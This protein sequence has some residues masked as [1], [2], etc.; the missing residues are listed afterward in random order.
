MTLLRV[1]IAD[2]EPLSRDCVRLALASHADVEVVGEC[3]DG[4]EAAE[5]IPRL[6]PDLVFLDVRMPGLDGFGVIEKVGAARMPPVVF[7]TA[8]D[9]HAIRA[10]SAHALDYVLKPFDDARFAESL[11]R[12]RAQ[13]ALRRDSELGRRLAAL[14]QASGS[15]PV[16]RL[17]V[18]RGEASCFVALDD[19]ECLAAERNYVR[20]HHRGGADIVRRTLDHLLSE[21]AG[22]RLVRVHRS[23]AVNVAHVREIRPW[24]SGDCIAVLESGREV[25][26]SRTYRS[27]LLKPFA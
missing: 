22:A 24:F 11:G 1:V 2:D 18:S 16:T 10:F 20:I 4:L 15:R 12:A 6:A 26:V 17:L 21:L 25:R 8:F 7:L 9:E 3:T 27:T 13:I 19:I 5:E 14:V 23:F